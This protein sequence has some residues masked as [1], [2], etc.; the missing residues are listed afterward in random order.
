MASPVPNISLL[1]VNVDSLFEKHRID[2]ID[3]LN[4]Q[5]Q[6][7]VEEKKEELRTMVG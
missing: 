5:L 2:A 3:S 4:K 7:N 1:D 6:I